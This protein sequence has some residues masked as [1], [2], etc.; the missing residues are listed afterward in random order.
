M[1][2][3]HMFKKIQ[4][5]LMAAMLLGLLA[6]CDSEQPQTHEANDVW[7]ADLNQHWKNCIQCD[8][9][10]DYADHDLDDAGI[11]SVC[12]AQIC[13]W[14][15]SKSLFLFTEDDDPL[16]LVDYDADGNVT[17]EL[18][19]SYTYDEDGNMTYSA[20]LTDGV[21]TSESN[22]IM[23]DG[24][25][26]VSQC[27]TYLDDGS[28]SVSDYDENGN[29]ICVTDY[30]ANGSKGT[31]WESMY[32]QDGD[33]QWYECSSVITEAD[34]S[35]VE[36]TYSQEGDQTS[37]ASYDAQG[38]FLFDHRWEYT[39]DDDGN[40]QTR[41]MYYNG[42]LTEEILF[43]TETDDGGSITYPA[44]VTEYQ[45]DGSKTVTCYDIHDNILSQ[46]HFD[47]DGNEIS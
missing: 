38:N 36:S 45:E 17:S 8:A 3:T 13:D 11:C 5:V 12:G 10:M 23:V 37:A 39:Y 24:E 35:R 6:A 14:G 2:E 25:R 44:T 7:N 26:M 34:G 47:A 46:T 41:I 16:K 9:A 15:D 31:V 29:E 18:F 22:Y 33:G 20:T 42:V 27:T 43:A 28:K 1:E 19:Y 4:A 21:L 32:A 40:W 30:L